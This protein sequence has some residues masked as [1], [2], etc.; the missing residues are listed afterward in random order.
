MARS[1]RLDLGQ[2]HLVVTAHDRVA[3]QLAHVPGQVVNERVV[4]IDD[5]D[6]ADVARASIRP[7]ALSSVSRYSCSG[8]DSATIPPPA[9]KWTRSAVATAVRMAMLLSSAPLTLQY[10]MAPQ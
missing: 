8:S 10:P 5:Q 4:V 3:A 6:H 7:R 1:E 2:R 9:L